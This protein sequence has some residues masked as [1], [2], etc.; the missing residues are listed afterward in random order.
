ML[1]LIRE[2]VCSK[3]GV[4]EPYIRYKWANYYWLCPNCDD[5]VSMRYVKAVKLDEKDMKEIMYNSTK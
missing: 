5:Y 3:C 2:Y 1:G 4:V